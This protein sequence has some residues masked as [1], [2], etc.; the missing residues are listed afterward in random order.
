MKKNK[1]FLVLKGTA[2]MGNRI[3]SFFE[4]VIYSKLTNRKLIVDWKDGVYAPA[5]V[6]SFFEF[7]E[8][9]ITNPDLKIPNTDSVYPSVWIGNLNKNLDDVRSKQDSKISIKDFYKVVKQKYSVDFSNKDYN[10]DVLVGLDYGFFLENF[11]SYLDQLPRE[12]PRESNA[13]MRHIFKNYLFLNSKIKRE[14]ERFVKKNFNGPVIGVH[15]RYTDNRGTYKDVDLKK[16]KPLIDRLLGSNPK[17]TIFLSTDNEEI[18]NEYKKIYPGILFFNKNF[19]WKPGL[20][21]HNKKSCDDRIRI[22]KE[23]LI[24]MYV[25]SKC[26]YIIY[27]GNSSFARL[28]AIYSDLEKNNLFDTRNFHDPSVFRNIY[29]FTSSLFLKILGY[30]GKRLKKYS[31]EIYYKL[32]PYFLDIK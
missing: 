25:L 23:A 16:Y 19:S 24:E 26:D 15:I 17:A 5:G 14:A 11:E 10:E 28:S 31:P 21:I 22:G 2:G 27:S 1:K 13:F 4:A 29:Y 32:K 7:F 3:M 18:L 9:P 6:N 20:E 30:T 8:S 12:W